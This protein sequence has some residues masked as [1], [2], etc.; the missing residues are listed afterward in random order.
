MV[1]EQGG[2]I[3][4]EMTSSFC[5]ALVRCSGRTVEDT[6]RLREA[7]S[8]GRPGVRGMGAAGPDARR[9]APQ[10]SPGEAC[11]R[12]RG[13]AGESRLLRQGR[14]PSAHSRQQAAV[15]EYSAGSRIGSGSRRSSESLNE[16]AERGAA[17]ALPR[18]P[19][20]KRGTAGCAYRVLSCGPGPF[21]TR[22]APISPN[23]LPTRSAAKW[24]FARLMLSR[25]D[26]PVCGMDLAGEPPYP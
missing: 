7:A 18:R 22:N 4:D 23:T 10:P 24:G 15:R 14:A 21:S 25:M 2:E 9:A 20:H 19:T 5:V 3:V 1:W 13:A 11:S 12:L 26:A 17:R 16:R 6:A 8:I